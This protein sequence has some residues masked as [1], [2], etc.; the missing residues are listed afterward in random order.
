MRLHWSTSSHLALISRKT[1]LIK[2]SRIVL[3]NFVQGLSSDISSNLYC[4][5]LFFCDSLHINLCKGNDG[6]RMGTPMCRINPHTVIA[7]MHE[8]HICEDHQAH[9]TTQDTNY[10]Q[11]HIGI[12]STILPILHHTNN[13]TST[14]IDA[15]KKIWY[16]Q[17][18]FYHILTE[19]HQRI[20]AHRLVF[21][22]SFFVF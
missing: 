4:V 13:I 17:H 21:I 9:R 22:F 16:I 10:M 7:L 8:L 2:Y 6:T 1:L 11:Y 12:W 5:S 18:R 19:H 20:N 14:T 15:T 3:S